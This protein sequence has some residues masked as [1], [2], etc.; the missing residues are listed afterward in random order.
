MYYPHDHS[1]A[2]LIDKIAAIATLE[3]QRAL[4]ADTETYTLGQ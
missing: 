2:Q 3:E 4:P 1:H